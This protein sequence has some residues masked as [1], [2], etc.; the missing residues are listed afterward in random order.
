MLSVFELNL[1]RG[2]THAEQSPQLY[3]AARGDCKRHSTWQRHWKQGLKAS[4]GRRGVA[5]CMLHIT[6]L[7]ECLAEVQ[8]WTAVPTAGHEIMMLHSAA[9]A[10]LRHASEGADP[11]QPAR[12]QRRLRLKLRPSS[13]C[14]GTLQSMRR[15]SLL[16]L[17][18]SLAWSPLPVPMRR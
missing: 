13:R 14:T 4:E 16:L 12:R 2:L 8:H 11:A 15:P 10:L 7:L 5:A 6:T 9:Q 3:I 18:A 1:D 17:G